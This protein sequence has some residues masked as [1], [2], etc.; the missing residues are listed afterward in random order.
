MVVLAYL[1]R[2]IW[3]KGELIEPRLNLV[4]SPPTDTTLTVVLALHDYNG[5]KITDDLVIVIPPGTRTRTINLGDYL[6]AQQTAKRFGSG[7]YIVMVKISETNEIFALPLIVTLGYISPPPI[8]DSQY[9]QY[10]TVFDR[11]LGTYINLPATIDYIP[12]DDRF[13][14]Y[15]Y[16]HRGNKGRILGLDKFGNIVLDT[17][18]HQL[19]FISLTLKFN[20]TWDMLTHM[21]AHS[22]GFTDRAVLS[23]MD[24]I[25]RRDYDTALKVL[26]PFYMITFLG[27]IIAV[28]FD[29]ANYEI[30]IKTQVYLGQ[31]DWGKIF[32]WGATGCGIAVLGVVALAVVTAGVGAITAPLVAGA[33]VAGGAIGMGL[34]VLTSASSDK[35]ETIIVYVD[36]VVEEGK[37]AKEQNEQYYNDAKSILD[38]W[39]RE[40]KITQDDYNEMLKALNSWKTAMDSAIDDIVKVSEEM[41]KKA[42]DDGYKEGYKKG[43]EESKTWIALSGVGGLLLGYMMGRR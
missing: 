6:N 8:P 7:F 34:A 39:L 11:L 13:W 32:S 3:A 26:R 17:G 12:S 33:C 16:L 27:R 20:R 18:Y 37:K 5:V 22:Y 24:A 23:V 10:Y 21:L 28:E 31:F 40:G 14:V 4:F 38:R 25:T 9:L 2:N 1:S 19:A 30:R 29:T 15:A 35:P 43:V 42:Y 41:I 36:R